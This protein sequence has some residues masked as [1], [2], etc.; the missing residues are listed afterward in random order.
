MTGPDIGR[1]AEVIVT[2]ASG[3]SRRG[4]GYLV[5]AGRVLTAAHA[6]E[7]GTAVRVRFDA[8]RPGERLLAAEVV[9]AHPTIDVAV[10]SVTADAAPPGGPARFGRVGER[11]AVLRCSAVGFP[12]FKLREDA[13]GSRYRDSEHV[14]GT[15]S[16][17]A[18]RREGTL[19]LRVPAPAGSWDGMSGAA[20][21]SDG[22]V[23][24]IV[25]LHHRSDGPG[26]LAVSRADR[27]ADRLPAAERRLLERLLHTELR[28]DRL[29]D[30]LPSPPAH[31]APAMAPPVPRHFVPRAALGQSLIEALAHGPVSLCG[32][33]GFGKTTLAAWAGRHEE[34]RERFPDGVLWVR[35]GPAP[36]T[37]RTVTVLAGLAAVLTGDA[38]V[39]HPDV[40][41][42][43]HAFRSALAKRRPLLVVDDVWAA[44]DLHPFRGAG[45]TLLVTT[46]RAGLLDDRDGTEI[47]V[48]A[49]DDDEAA[50]LLGL[51][52]ERA[53]LAPLLR[54]TGH[55][56][57]ALGLLSGP[58]R[59]LVS[60]RHAKTA[61]EAVAELLGELDREG[62]TALDELSE[63]EAAAGP[64]TVR[65]ISQTLEV[66]LADLPESSRERFLQLAAF[67]RGETVPYRLLQRLWGVSELRARAEG[68]RFIDRSLASAA[69]D[70]AGV[71]L[72][73]VTHE[74]LRRRA[75]DLPAAVSTRLLDLLRPEPGWHA[76]R[77]PDRDFL[78]TLG[79]HLDQAGRTAELTALV[80]DM[81]FL[82]VRLAGSGPLALESDLARCGE[83]P[84]ARELAEVL[85]REGH[86][87]VGGLSA[88]DAAV[89]LEYRLAG[90]TA[91]PAALRHA[92][93]A[94]P[95]HGLAA[96]HPP[97]DRDH[98]ALER[99][100]R[101]RDGDGNCA[102]LHW[103]P[104]GELLAVAGDGPAVRFFD[105]TGLEA[106]DPIEI[107][108]E[109]VAL[110]RWSPDGTHLALVSRR[111]N[112]E[113]TRYFHTLRVYEARTR[114]EVDRLPSPEP[115]FCWAPDSACLAVVCRGA[116]VDG[117]GLWQ[118]GSGRAPRVLPG[119]AP[120]STLGR[121]HLAALDWHPEHGL[122]AATDGDELS[123][124]AGGA[125]LLWAD[126][127][128]PRLPAVWPYRS[129][130]TGAERKAWRPTA[131]S[132]AWR[133]GGRSALVQLPDPLLVDP[134]AQRVLWR[135]EPDGHGARWS[136]DGGRL[137]LRSGSAGDRVRWALWRM[138]PD[139]D[140][141]RGRE[142]VCEAETPVGVLRTGDLG[143]AWRPDGLA[144]AT[145]TERRVVRIWR[146]E[147]SGRGPAGRRSP[148]LD[149]VMWSADGAELAVG[150]RFAGT[151]LSVDPDAP[152]AP[153]RECPPRP[154]AGTPGV[155]R[156]QQWADM[157]GTTVLVGPHARHHLL[158]HTEP[159]PLRV[160]D[161]SRGTTTVLGAEEGRWSWRAT[162]FA[163]GG[164]R[165]VAIGEH[166]RL[167]RVLTMWRLT[168]AAVEPPAARW[169]G[170]PREDER[171]RTVQDVR[172]LSHITVSD[173][174]VAVAGGDIIGLFALADL[175][176]LC[177]V[178]T[179]ATVWE[180]AFAPSGRR[181]AVVG[182]AGLQLFA[183]RGAEP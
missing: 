177:W 46:R 13:D 18:N 31:P 152:Q 96:L 138:P 104:A 146:T 68:D 26:R 125:L 172:A 62:I 27:W 37:E 129:L 92:A 112:P 166:P 145:T 132:L 115:G 157:S 168:G 105:R 81:R 139:A 54:R 153:W 73:D 79:F 162:C 48:T 49:M 159:G 169:P 47:P 147:P 70:G 130:G 53:V 57:L 98:E 9:F 61:A 19:D 56:P 82:A 178:R 133:P 123:A 94:R 10:L 111:M 141:A 95:A 137:A 148:R 103:H 22:R 100:F 33:G 52:D 40:P 134:S 121:T 143:A 3:T 69:P 109:S 110:V 122:L 64:D 59:S 36:T 91:T 160:V 5:S 126:P 24:G 67:P 88:G 117:A 85:R 101:A 74:A 84:A 151:W 29:P 15:C 128:G 78:P 16:V 171:N 179:N 108:D 4:S 1:V 131:E 38:P 58:V 71:R 45:A 97:P 174:H 17:L 35:L 2:T 180:V 34:I 144:I 93:E 25:V 149:A 63:A 66:S 87:F 60:S 65:G 165:V 107:A 176:R 156:R 11:D 21:F 12:A 23:V 161:R 77:G 44:A 181:L 89:T 6:V 14:H 173:D 80:R 142:P 55:W 140:L 150:D 154:F 28:P 30:V 124:T 135:A 43:A 20:V 127:Y 116:T 90:L 102:A 32:A 114:G 75:P 7:D 120:D 86:L 8:D 182:D 163:P 155:R 113:R 51:P 72:H 42:A 119:A 170:P 158:G 136:P 41:S 106:G 175:R 83:D 167:G 99:S 183:V 50:E 164:D 118:P 39:I 76:L